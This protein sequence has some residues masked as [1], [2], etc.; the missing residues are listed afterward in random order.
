MKGALDRLTMLFLPHIELHQGQ[1]VHSPRYEDYPALGF[2]LHKGPHDDDDA[3][4][5]GQY[6]R[7]YAFHFQTEPVLEAT[8]DSTPR[9]V[10]DALDCV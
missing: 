1:C 9:E 4:I 6:F 3:R 2:L 5:T 10:C 7:R 8:T